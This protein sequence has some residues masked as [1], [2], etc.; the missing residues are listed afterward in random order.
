MPHKIIEHWATHPRTQ[1]HLKFIFDA[2]K[3]DS[4]FQ[5]WIDQMVKDGI[6]TEDG[7]LLMPYRDGTFEGR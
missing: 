7:K 1:L 4:Q 2:A 6:C 3:N 5:R